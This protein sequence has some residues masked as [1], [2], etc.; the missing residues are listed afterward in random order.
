MLNNVK[1]GSDH[2]I[3]F[4]PHTPMTLS[5]FSILP[6]GS[7]RVQGPKCTPPVPPLTPPSFQEHLLGKHLRT[8]SV[9]PFSTAQC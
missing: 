6:L 7:V 9:T 4:M 5:Y 3:P 2:N 8:N 1:T